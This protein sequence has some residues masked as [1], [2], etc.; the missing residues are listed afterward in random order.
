MPLTVEV[1]EIDLH[2]GSRHGGQP[3]EYRADGPVVLHRGHVVVDLIG[4]DFA[5]FIDGQFN[6]GESS[7]RLRGPLQ[8]FGAH[9]LH[10]HR[11]ADGLRQDHRLIFR[12]GVPA[13]RS[14]IVAGA[15]IRVHDHMIGRGAEHHGNF[16]PKRLGILVVGVDVHR[17]VRLDIGNGH[18]RADRRVLHVTATDRWRKVSS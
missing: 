13:V 11:F 9:P 4:D 16:A 6:I 8:I 17:A 18:R 15:G 5:L 2:L 7:G 1:D 10:A 14:S 12:A 3:G